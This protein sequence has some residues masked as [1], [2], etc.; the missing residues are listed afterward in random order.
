MRDLAPQ[1]SGWLGTTAGTTADGRFVAAVRFDSA[2]SARRNADRPAQSQ[3]W[4][5]T[6][7][8]F[9]G[10]VTFH[11]CTEVLTLGD[12]G[13]DDAGFVQVIEGQAEPDRLRTMAAESA[14]ALRVYRPDVL[15]GTIGL[16]GDGGFTEVVYFTSEAA[17]REGEQRQPPPEIQAEMAET[18]PDPATLTFLDLKTPLL[19]SPR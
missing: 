11:D 10:E 7:A 5:K 14:S 1:A 6:S 2:E 8:L 9:T 13:S 18:F 3:W 4:E 17:A 19:Y 12:G 15:G 16:H